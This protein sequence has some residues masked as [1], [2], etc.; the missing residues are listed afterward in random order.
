MART[1]PQIVVLC[2]G[3]PGPRYAATRHNAGFLFG[4]Y[5]RERFGFGEFRELEGAEALAAEG[6]L[7]GLPALLV[8]PTTSMNECGRT[9]AALRERWDPDC[10][11][12]T[13]AHDD[14]DVPVGSAR[15]RAK[16]GHG[17]HNGVRSILEAAGRR[18]IARIKL[19]VDSATRAGY[20]GPVDF[21]LGQFDP[22]DRRQLEQSFPQAA[23]ILLGQVK[24][25]AAG[26][27][28][29]DRR[30]EVAERYEAE[31]LEEA[32][33]ALSQVPYA[34]PYP[35]FLTHAQMAGALDVA[36]AVAKLLR[37]ALRAAAEDDG[38]YGRLLEVVPEGL[39]PL[40]PP[41]GALDRIFFACDLHVS[42]AGMK[43]I[44]I[45]GAP[46]FGHFA[47]LADEAL[48]PLLSERIQGLSRPNEV[49]FADF[50]Y[51]QALRPRHDPAAG[52]LAFLR[53]FGNEDMFNIAEL[54]GIARRI[55][56]TGGPRVPL[57]HEKDLALRGD[58]LYLAGER[59]DL[60]YVEENLADWA[61]LDADSPL[62]EAV[63]RGVVRVAPALDVFLFTSKTFMALLADP[64]A[65]EFFAPDE[66][67]SKVL[68]E[69][70][71]WSS[72]LDERIEPAAY[73]MLDQGLPL[74]V[75]DAVGGGGRGVTVL[76]P[77]SS[78]QQA[79]HILRQRML[80]GGSV[81]QG[82][83]APGKWAE[84]SELNFDL[85]IIVSA[86]EGDIAIGPVYGR[87][88]RGEKLT[89]ADPGCGL[90]P[91]YVVD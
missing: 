27:R 38:F 75:K 84:G 82:Y 60:L 31:L 80:D 17:G 42:E 59:V 87:I 90:C 36:R 1:E 2:L 85:R 51:E 68:R 4:D 8:K 9:F 76:Q 64:A 10:V 29:R 56:Q 32:S 20:D 21:L 25:W 6:E 78:S 33:A 73:H 19:G 55:E 5:V 54:E 70:I 18:D 47:H 52:I 23:D 81:V 11:L 79:G 86:H 34:S 91:V 43:V 48:W 69:N 50:F 46:G 7:A 74:V 44:E 89:L 16:G 72:P 13:I 30:Q 66:E 39:R 58:G 88:F 77:E 71:L 14:L 67:E 63:R 53:G 61:G 28:R 40:L 62:A 3:N 41:R 49:R 65:R 35:V 57:C 12:Y 45:N 15:G 24:S 22:E 83:F 37:K 26:R